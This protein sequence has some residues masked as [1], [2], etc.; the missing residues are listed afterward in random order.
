MSLSQT[1]LS[2]RINIVLCGLRNAG[3]S[4][5]LNNLVGQNI[6]IISDEPGTTT[7][8][9][10]K[11]MEMG[12]LGPVSITDTAG[13]DDDSVLGGQRVA[14]SDEKIKVGHIILLVTQNHTPLTQDETQLIENCQ[15][16]NKTIIAILTH[17]D[18]S[19]DKSK[20]ETL[21]NCA[22]ECIEV[23]NITCEGI[24]TL[25]NKLES[26][27]DKIIRE[28]TPLE[29][30]V[31]EGQLLYL[32]TPVDSAAPKGRLILPQVETLRDALDRGC[33]ALVVQADRLADYYRRTDKPDLIITDSQAFAEVAAAVPPEQNLTS[34]SILFA[35]KKGDMD[36]FIEGLGQLRNVPPNSKILILESCTHH[37]KEDDIGTVKIPNLFRK[38]IREDVTFDFAHGIDTD[39]E[40]LKKY[41]LIITC[42][43]CMITRSV[44]MNRL[45]ILK[46][47]GIKITNYGLFLA[48][49]NG[50]LPRALE[51]LP[52]AFQKYNKIIT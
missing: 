34:F 9:V 50:L 14:K 21:H 23:N 47:H 2:E 19:P 52:E 42:G 46:E 26:L 33:G 45:H 18:K 31:N 13:I 35:R 1:P 41:H 24:E 22:I 29:G 30:I 16:N 17:A 12:K 44:M 6:A 27:S 49:V 8:P 4:S 28:I 5:L 40:T 20:Q 11:A 32:I 25:K 43:A 15:K 48:Y 3:K 10:T 38:K 39:I 7:D 36:Y 51:C 37:K